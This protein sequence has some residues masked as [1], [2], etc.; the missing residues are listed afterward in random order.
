MM[1]FSHHGYE[2]EATHRSRV[3]CSHNFSIC[4][5]NDSA[6]QYRSKCGESVDSPGEAPDYTFEGVAIVVGLAIFGIP[7]TLASSLRME[8]WKSRALLCI[9]T[10][11]E[12][13]IKYGKLVASLY[14]NVVSFPCP[15]SQSLSPSLLFDTCCQVSWARIKRLGELL[16]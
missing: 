6:E 1:Q 4:A 8:F 5:C 14:F 3:M 9:A 16:A 11:S 12:Q 7:C 2:N 10:E 13:P 15:W